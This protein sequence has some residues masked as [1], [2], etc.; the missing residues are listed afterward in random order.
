MASY[1]GKD[2]YQG[3]A[4][5]M[6]EMPQIGVGFSRCGTRA[7]AGSCQNNFVQWRRSP[8]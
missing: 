4:S 6:P 1:E 2:S 5:A 8:A 3:I 7:T